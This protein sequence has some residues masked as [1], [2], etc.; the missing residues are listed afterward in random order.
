M[1]Y[2]DACATI[3]VVGLT[4][5]SRTAVG[6]RLVRRGYTCLMADSLSEAQAR[7]EEALV[8]L[9]L[10]DSGMPNGQ[11][12]DFLEALRIRGDTP[13]MVLSAAS[14]PDSEVRFLDSG[15]DDFL[16][17]R[18]DCSIL[19]ARVRALIRRTRLFQRD[20]TSKSF[21]GLSLI[22]I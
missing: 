22:H 6:E 1:R 10:L 11:I 18:A 9:I 5:E 21:L 12:R 17:F 8:D 7:N 19:M 15:A 13:I 4:A 16:T 20:A 2:R 3:L 14:C